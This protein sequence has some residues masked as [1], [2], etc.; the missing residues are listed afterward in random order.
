M[1]HLI[2]PATEALHLNVQQGLPSA[3]LL[4][5]ENLVLSE[6]FWRNLF[7][8]SN[9]FVVEDLRGDARLPFGSSL[10][11]LQ[12]S[13]AYLG[14]AVSVKARPVGLFSILRET[15]NDL[16]MDDLALFMAI[17][18]QIGFFVERLLS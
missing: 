9:P 1:I 12:N 2:D 18:D 15:G 5:L 4:P 11:C 6:N 17:A 16:S 3:C 8:A 14:A 7:S 10:D 13:T